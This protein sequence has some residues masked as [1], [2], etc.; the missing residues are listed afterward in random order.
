MYVKI[1]LREKGETRRGE[2]FFSLSL[3]LL[4]VAFL[5]WS[6]FHARSR[7]ARSTVPEEKWRLLVVYL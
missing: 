1:A 4:R 7:F 6:D 5:A 3:S 2:R